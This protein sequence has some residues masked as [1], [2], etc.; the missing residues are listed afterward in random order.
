M[1]DMKRLG[2]LVFQTVFRF[3]RLIKLAIFANTTVGTRALQKWLSLPKI[4][5]RSKPAELSG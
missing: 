5:L 3:V 2:N 1:F 4:I